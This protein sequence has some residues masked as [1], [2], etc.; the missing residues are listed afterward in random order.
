[1]KDPLLV[2]PCNLTLS[3]VMAVKN[4]LAVPSLAVTTLR[5][6]WLDA[7]KEHENYSIN[8]LTPDYNSIYRWA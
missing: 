5:L 8:L 2:V 6:T 4:C 7:I 3:H 1:M